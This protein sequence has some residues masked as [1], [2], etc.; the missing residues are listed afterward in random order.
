MP[1]FAVPVIVAAD[2]G[3]RRFAA[4]GSGGYPILGG[5]ISATVA[6]LEHGL[7]AREAVDLPR[8]HSQGDRTYVESRVDPEVVAGLRERGHQLVVQ[9]VAPGELAFSR[10]SVVQV[11]GDGPMAA[12]AGPS[13]NTAAGG[14]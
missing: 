1:F 4:A 6:T 14:V 2:A 13:W 8:V 12:A 10:V 5:V 11:S 9:D 7:S 3:G